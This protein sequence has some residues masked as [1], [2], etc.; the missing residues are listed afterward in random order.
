[1]SA[2]LQNQVTLTLAAI[3]NVVAVVLCPLMVVCCCAIVVCQKRRVDSHS[4]L[5]FQSTSAG[6]STVHSEPIPQSSPSTHR[7]YRYTSLQ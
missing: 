1:M 5:P 7:A 2:S 4:E 3:A 6:P